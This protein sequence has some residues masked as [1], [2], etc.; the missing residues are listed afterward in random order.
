MRPS[1]RRCSTTRLPWLPTCTYT[2][3]AEPRA[4][5]LADPSHTCT[6]LSPRPATGTG[7][8]AGGGVVWNCNTRSG[9]IAPIMGPPFDWVLVVYSKLNSVAAGWPL[10]GVL[11]QSLHRHARPRHRT[12]PRADALI[13]DPYQR[14]QGIRARALRR[15]GAVD[16][17]VQYHGA[18]GVH[19]LM[20]GRHRGIVVGLAPLV[21]PHPTVVRRVIEFLADPPPDDAEHGA[22]RRDVGGERVAVRIDGVSGCASRQRSH[23]GARDPPAFRGL[24]CERLRPDGF[25]TGRRPLER[26]IERCGEP[27]ALGL[28]G[29][30][31]RV[32]RC[33]EV[34][35]DHAVN[36]ES[37]CDAVAPL[38]ATDRHGQ[39]AVG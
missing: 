2:R 7:A 30:R 9:T 26:S 24:T 11:G 23:D 38:A 33:P 32:A 22:P 20:P 27:L 4:S 18:L 14:A 31:Q 15:H 37:G 17:A 1:V 8:G 6:G 12:V 19:L 5:G 21:V 3:T 25:G 34:H 16:E 28:D 13:L 29:P 10:P 35:A 39:G 36:R